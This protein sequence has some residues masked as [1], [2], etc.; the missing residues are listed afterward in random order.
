MW[1]AIKKKTNMVSV[2]IFFFLSRE[3]TARSKLQHNLSFFFLP[4][5]FAN[6]MF[7]AVGLKH[8][9]ESLQNTRTL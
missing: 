5:F 2:V 3:Y 8:F 9:W 4:V 7:Y 1:S 6:K